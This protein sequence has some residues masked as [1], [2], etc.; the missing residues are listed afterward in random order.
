[1]VTC[2]LWVD[3][4]NLAVKALLN[5][6]RSNIRIK[7][8]REGPIGVI[9]QSGQLAECGIRTVATDPMMIPG[10]LGGLW[11]STSPH[12]FHIA[13]I[14]IIRSSGPFQPCSS[15]LWTPLCV[16][17][18]QQCSSRHSRR[19]YLNFHRTTS[20]VLRWTEQL[21]QNLSA[22]FCISQRSLRG[23]IL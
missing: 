14:L 15:R 17:C 23:Q 7:I 20:E 13:H 19:L 6:Q 18:V 9:R 11:L 1:M 10:K 2:F 16:C 3:T 8:S 22:A 21:V 12:P 4:T 5:N